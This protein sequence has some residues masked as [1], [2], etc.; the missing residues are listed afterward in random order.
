MKERNTALAVVN[1][2]TILNKIINQKK[3]DKSYKSNHLVY[4]NERQKVESKTRDAIEGIIIRNYKETKKE[5]KER[6]YWRRIESLG[7]S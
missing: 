2:A 5:K 1:S 6:K 3:N 4:I 7:L